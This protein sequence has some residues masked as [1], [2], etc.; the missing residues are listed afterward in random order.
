[1]R[2]EDRAMQLNQKQ[3]RTIVSMTSF[4]DR[5]AGLHLTVRSLL[6]Q[7]V[8]ADLLIIWLAASQFPHGMDDVP[9]SLTALLS[10]RCVI[11]WCEDYRSYKK[12]IPTLLEFPDSTV[13]T[14]DDDIIYEP[15][16]IEKLLRGAEAHPDCVIASRVTKVN[17][18]NDV[19]FVDTGG[20]SYWEN[21]SYL[22][23]L[24]GCAGCLYPPHCLDDEVQ[25]VEAFMSLAPTSDDV[26]FW[27]MAAK[28]AT[29]V[30]R[31]ADGDWLPRQ[32]PVNSGIKPLSR[33]NDGEL[34]LF[35]RHLD[36]V[37]AA[38]P[39]INEALMGEGAGS[40][41][42]ERD[43]RGFRVRAGRLSYSMRRLPVLKQAYIAY[44]RHKNERLAVSRY[45][46]RRMTVLEQKVSE[47]MEAHHDVS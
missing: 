31:I 44:L 28:A 5:M 2:G 33:A 6:E 8:P 12:L 43:D 10:E 30:Y 4:P 21:P 29:K 16:L 38:Y 34:G 27:L 32:N 14:A 47:S 19:L 42:R 25:N 1:M 13:I 9:E 26:W 40:G 45:N 7:T 35:Y 46:A 15:K 24:V 37:R 11:G 23:K 3:P 41:I 39:D 22:N 18:I 17:R 36:N 20:C